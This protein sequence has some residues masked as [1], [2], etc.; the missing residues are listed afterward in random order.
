MR[1]KTAKSA[2]RKP[3]P[4]L[5]S[6]S[7][8]STHAKGHHWDGQPLCLPADTSLHECSLRPGAPAGSD[9]VGNWWAD[10][11]KRGRSDAREPEAAPSSNS[12]ANTQFSS[13]SLPTLWFNTWQEK[14]HLTIFISSLTVSILAAMGKSFSNHNS[15][16]L[17]KQRCRWLFLV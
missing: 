1:L 13:C 11:L 2:P 6:G 15:I 8:Q 14:G 4:T 7:R 16:L 3:A 5:H 12:A 17:C 10:S 9:Y